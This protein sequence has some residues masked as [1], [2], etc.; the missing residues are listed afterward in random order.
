[1]V[2]HTVW[3]KLKPGVMEPD[4]IAMQHSLLAMRGN[5]PGVAEIAC[6][7]DFSGRS[8]GF[9]VG[10]VVSLE[11]RQALDEYGPHPVHQAFVEG[12]RHLWTEVMALDFES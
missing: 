4:K 11:S 5:I 1:M 10:L 8:Q 7:T 3:F 6:G 12:F 2:W 9:D